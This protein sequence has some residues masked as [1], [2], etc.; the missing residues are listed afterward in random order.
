MNTFLWCQTV[1]SIEIN[2]NYCL[3]RN[4]LDGVWKLKGYYRGNIFVEHQISETST[5]YKNPERQTKTIRT[6][7][8]KGQ[9]VKV[10]ETGQ[11]TVI[12]IGKEW[13]AISFF[14]NGSHLANYFS[15]ESYD[16]VD[17]GGLFDESCQPLVEITFRNSKSYLLFHGM[18]GDSEVEF[19][20]KGNILVI[21][22]EKGLNEHY[23]KIDAPYFGLVVGYKTEIK[24]PCRQELFVGKDS[25][26]FST[27]SRRKE[28][29]VSTIDSTLADLI[30]IKEILTPALIN[31]VKN[32]CC[33][34]DCPDSKSGYYIM[35]SDG[36]V[37]ERISI[38]N[39]LTTC[40]SSIISEIIEIFDRIRIN[41]Q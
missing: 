37:D 7:T 20:F 14:F 41:Y 28:N 25:S 38:N 10:F 24:D 40:S 3:L 12:E 17:G 8:K 33:G 35:I 15:T 23:E 19:K 29:K 1:D 5:Y 6:M 32:C 18:T 26:Y 2:K 39:D 11:P 9:V 36:I 34:A 27:C 31:E 21:K 4:K 30:R 13:V 22:S 16:S